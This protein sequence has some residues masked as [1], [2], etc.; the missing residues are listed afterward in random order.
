MLK[1]SATLMRVVA[2]FLIGA[3]AAISGPVGSASAAELVMYEQDGC[4]WCQVWNRRIAPIYPNTTEGARAPLRRVDIDE[5]IPQ[6][7]AGI[8]VSRF[9]PTFVL[10]DGGR[11]VGRIVGYPGEDFFWGFLENLFAKLDK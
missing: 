5:A 6:D 8:T 9:T 2:G 1:N 7:L 4:P 3:F 10:V 11:E